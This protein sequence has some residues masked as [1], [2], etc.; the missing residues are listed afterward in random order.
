MDQELATSHIL[1]SGMKLRASCDACN[2]TKVKC[3]KEKPS[4][5]RCEAHK[6]QCAY[7][8]SLRAGKRTATAAF[9]NPLVSKMP[10]LQPQRGAQRL[11]EISGNR[12]E[13]NSDNID[14]ESFLDLQSS[15][16]I[17]QDFR[18]TPPQGDSIE[19]FLQSLMYTGYAIRE[20]N[21]PA[22][23]AQRKRA[24]KSQSAELSHSQNPEKSCGQ[25]RPTQVMDHL[26]REDKMSFWVASQ[27][28]DGQQ[29]FD[30]TNVASPHTSLGLPFSPMET[31]SGLSSQASFA[32]SAIYHTN[33]SS[34]NVYCPVCFPSVS[35]LGPLPT[36]PSNSAV[37]THPG[38]VGL[39]RSECKCEAS[40]L[41][42]QEILLR[43]SDLEKISFDLALAANKEV[44]K[45]CSAIL[46]CGCI[47]S[48]DP[49]AITL[50]SIMAKAISVYWSRAV[51]LAA[52][53]NLAEP[54]DTAH[55]KERLLT[56]GAYKLDE[57]DEERLKL[58]VVLIEL[59]KLKRLILNF[60]KAFIKIDLGKNPL[61]EARPAANTEDQDNLDQRTKS[62]LW[63]SLVDLLTRN[64]AAASLNLR[65]SIYSED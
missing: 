57:A 9:T 5:R 11:E 51:S 29:D 58:E 33:A 40:M 49:N 28:F 3:S 36:P 56:I 43:I 30:A 4:C 2:Q 48:D 61:N 52:S 63:Q 1:H 22:S 7:G 10:Q 24:K 65:S 41:S 55:E 26:P 62:A 42:A 23:A 17:D 14:S 18:Q 34:T 53:T 6:I 45:M 50:S 35:D 8:L 25:S 15:S 20:S 16:L 47:L 19:D 59:S 46:D 12:E 44:L 32:G 27:G 21:Y 54:T 31:S 64:L 13:K 39:E 60:K 38:I 37:S